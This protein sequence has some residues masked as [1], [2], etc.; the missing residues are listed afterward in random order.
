M[1]MGFAFNYFALP[2]VI[3]GFIDSTIGCALIIGSTF[4][5]KSAILKR[6]LPEKNGLL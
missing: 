6:S 1:L 4:Y 5:F 2:V 3:R